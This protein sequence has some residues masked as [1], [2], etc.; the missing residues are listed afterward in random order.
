VGNIYQIGSE[1][2]HRTRAD[3]TAGLFDKQLAF[4]NDPSRLKS[5]V[6]SRRAGKTWEL[7]REEVKIARKY[8]GSRLGYL[9]KTRD[10]AADLLWQPLKNFDRE[11]GLRIDFN[12]AKLRATFPNGSLIQ[13]AGAKDK[14]QPEA[15]RGF[16]YK[17]MVMDEV[18]SIHPLIM[19]YI[20]KE[21]MPAALGDYK[22]TLALV[23]TP[24]DT[25]QG[26]F[27]DMTTDPNSGFSNHHWTVR[28]NP[29]FPVWAGLPNWRD[30]VE[31]WLAE[32]RRIY[33]LKETDPAYLR[34]YCG[35]WV[36]DVGNF[37][38]KPAPNSRIDELPEQYRDPETS[39]LRYVT[40]IDLGWVD[41][42]AWE[43]NGYDQNNQKVFHVDE[44]VDNH[45]TFEDIKRITTEQII[46]VYNPES[47]RVDAAG[48]GK[49][50]QESL[51]LDFA[52]RFGIPCTAAKKN[53]K[54]AF[55]KTA[56]TDLRVGRAFVLKGSQ[57]DKQMQT[58]Q[59]DKRRLREAEGQECDA[60]DGWLYS[61]RDCAHWIH[62]PAKRII[63]PAG[64]RAYA[65]YTAEEDERVEMERYRQ[66]HEENSCDFY[67]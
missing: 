23:G 42:V 25:C 35:L 55:M 4:L 62:K 24:N 39:G 17:L 18:G 51:A 16:A 60:H 26:Y 28:D 43:T 54:G 58:L 45:L 12:N 36:R 63:P 13:L 44:I 9:T 50:I 31:P 41:S 57:V 2:L 66:S 33:G 34:E 3:V 37:I 27:H 20:N 40:G 53:K 38:Y 22:G 47:I 65:Q 59:W 67:G 5:A 19:E 6:C 8:P 11:L 46:N 21:I 10:W 64:T 56:D 1:F 14:E 29:M 32:E 48:A 15:L 52:Q 30:Y 7:L 49:I 61:Y